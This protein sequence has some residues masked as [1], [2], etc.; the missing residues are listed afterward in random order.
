MDLPGCFTNNMTLLEMTVLRVKKEGF[1]RGMCPNIEMEL[2][3]F[4]NLWSVP[5]QHSVS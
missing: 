3:S 2:F 1:K 4:F 5:R